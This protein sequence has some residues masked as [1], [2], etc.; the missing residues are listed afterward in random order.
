M[1]C[2]GVLPAVLAGG[3]GRGTDSGLVPIGADRGRGDLKMDHQE[4]RA[5]SRSRTLALALFAV[6]TGW[7]ATIGVLWLTTGQ[8]LPTVNIRWVRGI[9][10]EDR[11]RAEKDLS[12]VVHQSKEPGTKSYFL[13]DPTE[14]NLRRIVLLPF[15][16]DTAF[17]NRGTFS[18]EGAPSVRMWFGDR[19]TMPW[20]LGSLYLSLFGCLT[21]GVIL[22]PRD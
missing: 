8:T 16:E 12:L 2:S 14:Q 20:L 1:I 10:A 18:L 11:S 21:S 7:Q 17:I 19:H 22:A 6:C 9:T 15:V 3:L 13:L 5:R 4:S